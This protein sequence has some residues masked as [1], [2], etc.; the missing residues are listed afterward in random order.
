MT[1]QVLLDAL[2]KSFITLDLV[3]LLIL[4]ECHRATGSHPYSVIMTV[5]FF[6]EQFFSDF[7][8]TSFPGCSTLPLVL[9][10]SLFQLSFSQPNSR[11]NGNN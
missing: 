8:L 3:Q 6:S 10:V 2:R 1:P 5:A 7:I 4:D 9:N 11:N